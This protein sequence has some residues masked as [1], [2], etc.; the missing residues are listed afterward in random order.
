MQN[1]NVKAQ[2]LLLSFR[3]LT[4]I[5]RCVLG[6]TLHT[7]RICSFLFYKIGMLQSQRVS[8]IAALPAIST[9]H[10]CLLLWR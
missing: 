6:D 1:M 10:S 5:I 4:V 3:I 8:C 7:S 2:I 9:C